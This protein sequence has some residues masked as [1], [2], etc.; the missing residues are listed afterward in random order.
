MNKDRLPSHPEATRHLCQEASGVLSSLRTG[1]PA[2]A[3][4]D[5]VSDL[6]SLRR[7]LKTEH[8]VEVEGNGVGKHEGVSESVDAQSSECKDGEEGE[9]AN[10]LLDPFLAVVLDGQAFGRHTLAALRAIYRLLERGSL[11][12]LVHFHKL[13][14]LSLDSVTKGVL[15]CKFEQTD[16][17]ED[18]LVEMA[19]A[20]LLGLLIALDSAKLVSMDKDGTRIVNDGGGDRNDVDAFHYV[21]PLKSETRM[22]AFTTVFL[23]RNT[24]VHSPALCYHIEGVLLGMISA[25][26]SGTNDERQR[27][28][29]K[30]SAMEDAAIAMLEFLTQQLLHTPLLTPSSGTGGVINNEAQTLHDATRVLCMKLVRCVVREV[31]GNADREESLTISKFQDRTHDE[32]NV[33]SLLSIV[34]DELC[35]ALLIIGQVAGN[36]VL[37]LEVLSEVCA[38]IATLWGTSPFLRKKLYVHFEAIINGFFVRA[39]AQLRCRPDPVDSEQYELNQSFDSECEIILESLVD[40]MCVLDITKDSSISTLEILFLAYDCNMN[41]PNVLARLFDELCLCCIDGEKKEMR[42]VSRSDII[43]YELYVLFSYNHFWYTKGTSSP[44]RIMCGN[45]HCRVEMC[46]A[47]IRSFW[48]KKRIQF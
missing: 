11:L 10:R 39:L 40:M 8:L 19:L 9:D 43:Q 37:S 42:N 46:N 36:D 26:F 28:N 1:P 32:R 21:T 3:Y 13:K 41:C 27:K 12:S 35:L 45:S 33:R 2:V 30:A 24:F 31:W 38:T 4:G 23:A 5:L 48:R 18:E 44:E 20:D 15:G 25:T 14:S 17:A 16:V 22:E 47:W 29:V 6:R 7:S 34:Q